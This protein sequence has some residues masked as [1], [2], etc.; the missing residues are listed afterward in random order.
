MTD[1]L[2]AVNR[3]DVRTLGVLLAVLV[4]GGVVAVLLSP[5]PPVPALSV[6]GEA[7]DGARLLYLWLAEAGYQPQEMTSQP[8]RLDSIDALFIL[9]PE[10]LYDDDELTLIS[11]WVARG[12]TLIVAGEPSFV[13]GPLRRFGVTLSRLI[14]DVPT[15]GVVSPASPLLDS[16]PA[17]PARIFPVY[18]VESAQPGLTIANASNTV[19]SGDAFVAHMAVGTRPVLVSLPVGEGQVWVAGM[20]YPFSNIGLSRDPA[21]ARLILNMLAGLPLGARIGFDEVRHGFGDTPTTL[22]GLLT[23]TSPGWGVLIGGLTL[24]AYVILRGRR[25]RNPMPLPENRLRREPVEY[26]Q[27]IANLLRRSGERKEMLRHFEAQLRRKL[28]EHYAIDPS[29]APEQ[30][31]KAVCA[32][33]PEVDENGLRRIFAQLGASAISEAQLVRLAAEIDAIV[34]S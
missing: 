26:I 17:E 13:E 21:N 27:A 2:S 11:N 3:R 8:M 34:K 22:F 29:L 24:S 15:D 32:R 6:R 19:K 5:Q 33:A 25:L 20:M 23:G 7:A 9:N 31:V 10:S 14:G 12:N 28:S 16:P 30:F 4:I 18:T 1:T